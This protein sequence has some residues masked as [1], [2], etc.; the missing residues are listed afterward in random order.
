MHPPPGLVWLEDGLF[1]VAATAWLVIIG[2]LVVWVARG[3][4]RNN[5]PL[6]W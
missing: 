2:G 6:D 4:S 3:L 5:A 1:G